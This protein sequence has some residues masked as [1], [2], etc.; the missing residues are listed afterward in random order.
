MSIIAGDAEL[1]RNPGASSVVRE[2]GAVCSTDNPI[3]TN[4]VLRVLREGGNAVDAAIAASFVQATVEPFMSNHAGSLTFLYYEAKTGTVHALDS[5][6]TLPAGLALFQPVPALSGG[7]YSL[8]GAQPSGAIPGFMPGLKEIHARFATRDWASLVDEAIGWAEDGHP[9]SSFELQAYVESLQFIAYFAEGRAL[10][11]PGGFLPPVGTRA[12]NPALAETLR[13]LA[14]EGPDYFTTGVWARHFV[15]KANT[16]GWEITLDHLTA[17]APRWGDPVRYRFRDYEL[18][19]LPLPQQVGVMSVLVLGIVEHV[20]GAAGPLDSADAVEVMA[21]ALRLA[22]QQC[23]YINDPHVFD[24]PLDTWLDPSFHRHLASLIVRSRTKVD[25][26]ESI[27]KSWGPARLAAAGVPYQSAEPVK[28]PM[29]SCELAIVDAA[30]N[31]VQMMHTL[32]SGGIPAQVVDGVPMLGSHATPGSLGS[33]MI[34]TWLVPGCRMRSA[35]GNTIAL[36]NGQPAF[37]LGTP[38]AP[39]ITIPQVLA[40]ILARGMHYVAAA[41]AP[42]MRPLADDYS[43]TIESRLSAETKR[44]LTARGIRLNS[45]YE[46]DWHMGSF[47]IA[48]RE[49]SGRLGAS[50]DPRRCG[51]AGGL[52]T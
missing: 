26:T 16:M 36:K 1:I 13:A 42:R 23:G 41:E 15:E 49:D 18:V 6:G 25:L 10:F 30:G 2:R 20:E 4:T 14:R 51:V 47:Q 27:A 32:Q 12:R 7:A 43:L 22:T 5:H 33:D 50:A 28:A 37:S 24:V 48:W 39:H 3:V 35:I 11:M 9:V 40:N 31:W 19:H 44:Q 21:H 8:A 52:D 45:A 17:T 46:H 38:G 29:G 34:S